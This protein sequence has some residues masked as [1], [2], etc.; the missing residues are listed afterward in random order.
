M[1]HWQQE[2][3]AQHQYGRSQMEGEGVA[4]R[5]FGSVP[6]YDGQPNGS[7]IN[8]KPRQFGGH[9]GRQQGY[10]ANSNFRENGME[11]EVR[12]VTGHLAFLKSLQRSGAT[13]RLVTIH[14]ETVIGSVKD[15]DEMTISIRV[16][17]AT[18][19]NPN[20]YQNRV[21]FKQNLVEF[22]PVVEG[23]TFS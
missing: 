1:Q 15:C 21:F 18:E 4:S 7:F 16:P 19:S 3:D 13:I 12:R 5:P 17:C 8:H 14:D 20:A 22:A 11:H 9:N 6:Q 10:N 23:V 2:L